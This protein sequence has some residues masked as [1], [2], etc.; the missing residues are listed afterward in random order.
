M[1]FSRSPFLLLT[2]GHPI[3]D[4]DK[5]LL[6]THQT[7]DLEIQ[8]HLWFSPHKETSC[9]KTS[10]VSYEHVEFCSHCVLEITT[11]YK[12]ANWNIITKDEYLNDTIVY[13]DRW[14]CLGNEGFPTGEIKIL[15][16]L[17]D[18]KAIS[19]LF[20]LSSS[21]KGIMT[22]RG[23]GLRVQWTLKAPVTAA[24][25]WKGFS[26]TPNLWYFFCCFSWLIGFKANLGPDGWQLLLLEKK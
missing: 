25:L 13:F 16:L 24:G 11:N 20:F 1:V 2:S 15:K 23:T 18:L 3:P 5:L 26:E 14:S 7:Y 8:K 6:P 21:L 4:T 19:I 9:L 12:T 10:T 17:F 22:Q